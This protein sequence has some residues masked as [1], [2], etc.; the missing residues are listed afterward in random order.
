[1]RSWRGIHARLFR[2]GVLSRT[3]VAQDGRSH[4][5]KI[6]FWGGISGPGFHP[7]LGGVA[8]ACGGFGGGLGCSAVS[9]YALF[10][11]AP[12]RPAP[13]RPVPLRSVPSRP[14]PSCP[15]P[16]RPAPPRIPSGVRGSG[17]RLRRI[18][19]GGLGVSAELCF[20][21]PPIRVADNLRSPGQS[22]SYPRR[23]RLRFALDCGPSVL[24]RRDRTAHRRAV[25]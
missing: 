5:G 21:L 24:F 22:D 7:G 15:A 19:W 18:R 12:F 11:S 2:C 10:R 23:T 9:R 16:S 20:R 14:A 17:I 13:L 6:R 1:M 25:R 8:S 3:G 4:V